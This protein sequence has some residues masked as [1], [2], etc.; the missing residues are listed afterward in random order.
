MARKVI[1][2]VEVNT[3]LKR[4]RV[5]STTGCQSTIL[6]SSPEFY[7]QFENVVNTSVIEP[8][9][10]PYSFISTTN[11]YPQIAT[12][13]DGTNSILGSNNLDMPSG[14][15]PLVNDLLVYNDD[16]PVCPIPVDS[17][18]LEDTNVTNFYTAFNL[19]RD[20]IEIPSYA[21]VPSLEFFLNGV[22][23]PISHPL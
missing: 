21:Q 23:Q 8:A 18:V 6:D 1:N 10:G 20:Q 17:F 11:G 4:V 3:T 9:V 19:A 2:G 5:E 14:E 13:V 16:T 15:N 7:W 22:E 12:G